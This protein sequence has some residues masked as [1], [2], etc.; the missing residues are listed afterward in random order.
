M[1]CATPTN[2]IR[3]G[4]LFKKS[5][6]LLISYGFSVHRQGMSHSFELHCQIVLSQFVIGV[7]EP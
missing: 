4:A 7:Y 1:V 5:S 6:Y 2:Q 3:F